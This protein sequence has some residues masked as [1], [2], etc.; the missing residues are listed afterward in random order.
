METTMSE[1]AEHALPGANRASRR[2]AERVQRRNR[3]KIP[4][5][6]VMAGGGA[7]ND[8][9]TMA[10][11][12][13]EH[14]DDLMQLMKRCFE[15]VGPSS[16]PHAMF[17]TGGKSMLV[18][19]DPDEHGDQV[20]PPSLAKVVAWVNAWASR[21]KADRYA[22]GVGAWVAPSV[23]AN[24]QSPRKC[25]LVVVDDREKGLCVKA[26]EVVHGEKDEEVVGFNDFAPLDL[27]LQEALFRNL[28]PPKSFGT[29]LAA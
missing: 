19:G 15:K 16:V 10:L 8:A 21:R 25:I 17:Y 20:V 7:S 3:T 27:R 4:V 2:R 9:T 23:L 6:G 18:V 22:L 11:T 12:P 24:D 14:A 13:E 28:L 1:F 29:D 26:S 5:F